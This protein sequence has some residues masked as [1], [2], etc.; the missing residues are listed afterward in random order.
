M[1]YSANVMNKYIKL[2]P[3]PEHYDTDQN[4]FYTS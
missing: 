3:N 1:I 2:G 4:I